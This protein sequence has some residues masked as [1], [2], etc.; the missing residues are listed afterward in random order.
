MILVV[1]NIIF[2]YYSFFRANQW[3]YWVLIIIISDYYLHDTII[4][5]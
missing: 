1:N 5:F 2:Q 3:P 4:T